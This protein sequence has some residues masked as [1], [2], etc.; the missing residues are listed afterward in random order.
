MKN[1]MLNWNNTISSILILDIF[2]FSKWFHSQINF[3]RY[4]YQCNGSE[5]ANKYWNFRRWLYQITIK[6]ICLFGKNYALLEF[7]HIGWLWMCGGGCT[8]HYWHQHS[9]IQ[10]PT[11]T[12]SKHYRICH[13]T[14]VI[15][16]SKYTGCFCVCSVSNS[17]KKFLS[18]RFTYVG[19]FFPR[20]S[21]N[22]WSKTSLE[23]T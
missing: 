22:S 16:Q 13:K 6:R 12:H 2:F 3:C 9:E 5:K 8:V 10:N 1:E 4:A 23:K 11:I 15:S 19:K 21:S 18:E 14:R 20:F 7:R 17:R